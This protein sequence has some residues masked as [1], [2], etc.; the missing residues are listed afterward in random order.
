M[1]RAISGTI[2]HRRQKKT[3]KAVRGHRGAVR[4]NYRLAREAVVRAG[5]Y[6]YRDRRNFKREMRSL[7]ITRISAACRA[8]GVTYSQFV[9]A[10]RL[11]NVAINR[12]ML[13]EIAIHD[14]AGFDKIV[15]SVRAHLPARAA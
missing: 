14:P 13:S 9:A 12:K 6:A 11:T 3:L 5:C 15:E 4:R 10:L 2:H 8:R 1:P 7:W